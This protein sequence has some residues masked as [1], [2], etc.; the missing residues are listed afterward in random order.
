MGPGVG[1]GTKGDRVVIMRSAQP[2]TV[3]KFTLVELLV[4]IAII[5]IL[6]AMLLPSLSKAKAAGRTASCLSNLKQL[7][8]SALMYVGDYDGFY[9]P[10]VTDKSGPVRILKAVLIDD[11]Y[12]TDAK[13]I[14][15][16]PSNKV[17]RLWAAG[18][19]DYAANV[20]RFDEKGLFARQA[21]GHGEKELF[22]AVRTTDLTKVLT[23]FDSFTNWNMQD[24]TWW[25]HLKD[26]RDTGFE[27]L[28][29][30]GLGARHGMPGASTGT[31]NSVHADGSGRTT[32]FN[33][34]AGS[35]EDQRRDWTDA[36][37]G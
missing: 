22:K 9:P 4:V 37:R 12:L 26:F 11:G 6:A 7:N 33:S 27:P 16:C 10:N 36:D 5:A 28:P 23:F 29:E 31:F 24:G 13:D 35:T 3:A 34:F 17:E 18:E 2:R 25:C 1:F 20:R 19:P 21:W 32:H 8:L 15:F 30:K 14:W